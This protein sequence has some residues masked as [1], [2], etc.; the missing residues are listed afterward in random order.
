MIKGCQLTYGHLLTLPDR[1]KVKLALRKDCFPFVSLMI[2]A[3]FGRTQTPG[4][5]DLSFAGTGYFTTA[6]SAYENGGRSI[7]L[8]DDGKIVVAGFA[9]NASNSDF[10]VVRYTEEGS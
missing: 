9:N 6:V 2:I 4:S 7:A 8:Q 1:M 5:L 10:A 3:L